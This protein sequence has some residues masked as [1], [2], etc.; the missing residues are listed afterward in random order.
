MHACQVLQPRTEEVTLTCPWRVSSL[1]TMNQ[2]RIC[3]LVF[4]FAFNVVFAIWIEIGLYWRV[5]PSSY[6]FKGTVYW[7]TLPGLRRLPPPPPSPLGNK[8]VN[9]G[10]FLQTLLA[11]QALEIYISIYQY[12]IW[13]K[14]FKICCAFTHVKYH[15]IKAQ[16]ICLSRNS[17]R[18][19][20]PWIF[21]LVY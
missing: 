21:V 1:S 7:Q 3:R 18:L 13:D 2:I 20:W 12:G 14:I 5:L 11:P 4:L 9:F 10:R 19:C 8:L 6:Q 16:N 17:C 15:W